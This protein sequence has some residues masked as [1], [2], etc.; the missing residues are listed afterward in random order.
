MLKKVLII[1]DEKNLA[2]VLYDTLC[3]EF[4]VV[5]ATNFLSK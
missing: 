5:K 4:S 2:T 1:E 3:D